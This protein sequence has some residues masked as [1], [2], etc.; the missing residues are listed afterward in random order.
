MAKE[1]KTKD[2]KE[3]DLGD[4]EFELVF[5]KPHLTPD[6]DEVKEKKEQIIKMRRRKP[7]P[8]I[9]SHEEFLEMMKLNDKE[10]KGGKKTRKRKTKRKRN[11]K[12]KTQKRK[13]KK[14][15]T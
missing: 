2:L 8:K 13:H 6:R 14:R 11:K 15:R 1:T 7:L 9:N 10:K 12:R 5:E 3:E 4:M